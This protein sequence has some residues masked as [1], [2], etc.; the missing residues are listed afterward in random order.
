MRL[1]LAFVAALAV[2]TP[3]MAQQQ[4][5]L[6]VTPDEAQMILN[7]LAKK[8]WQDINPVMSKLIGQINAQSAAVKAPPKEEPK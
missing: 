1:A 3:A 4:F 6:S 8:P 7:I 2:T 5:T